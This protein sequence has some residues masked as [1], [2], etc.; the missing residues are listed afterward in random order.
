[1]TKQYRSFEEI[2]E[3]LRILDL[4]RAIDKENLKLN[5]NSA[6]VHLLPSPL[7]GGLGLT[8]TLQKLAL[9]FVLKKVLKRFRDRRQERLLQEGQQE[10][11]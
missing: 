3:R 4:Q 7:R 9:S 5:L 6:K 11:T 2:D 10:T 1:M 8:G